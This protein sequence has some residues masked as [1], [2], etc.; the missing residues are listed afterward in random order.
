M[1]EH[2]DDLTPEVQDESAE[3]IESFPDPA[4]APDD[5][6]A[7]GEDVVGSDPLNVDPDE[8]EM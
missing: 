5:D 3:E 8:T 2:D 6:I 1:D 4:D 7:S